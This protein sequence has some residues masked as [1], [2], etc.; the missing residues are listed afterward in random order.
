MV[1]GG[2]AQVEEGAALHELQ[3]VPRV[4][5]WGGH[6]ARDARRGALGES[7]GARGRGVHEVRE[8]L[9][10][11]AHARQVGQAS[12]EGLQLLVYCFHLLLL[13]AF[14]CITRWIVELPLDGGQLRVYVQMV[15]LVHVAR[16]L[17]AAELLLRLQE[18]HELLV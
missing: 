7:T 5:Q 14:E 3:P 2:V 1:L 11:S 8:E 16:L 13:L 9:L 17:P 10:E 15:P 18:R 4:A 6:S 12:L